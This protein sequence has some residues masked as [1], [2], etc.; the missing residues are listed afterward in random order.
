[1]VE[2]GEYEIGWSVTMKSIPA[3]PSDT[4]Y[5]ARCTSHADKVRPTARTRHCF[6]GHWP[7]VLSIIG[8]T[9][10]RQIALP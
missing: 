8:A 10:I 4:E 5:E 6:V 7:Y 1:M 2:I 9:L 3:Y